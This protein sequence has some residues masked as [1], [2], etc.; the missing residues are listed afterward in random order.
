MLNNVLD[1]A[2]T[3]LSRFQNSSKLVHSQ[4]LLIIHEVNSLCVKNKIQYSNHKS[5]YI[6]TQNKFIFSTPYLTKILIIQKLEQ[7]IL[8]CMKQ[9]MKF[10]F[11]SANIQVAIIESLF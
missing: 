3:G 5:L 2:T 9:N 6:F 11:I 1:I 8:Y 4:N 10:N 7:I